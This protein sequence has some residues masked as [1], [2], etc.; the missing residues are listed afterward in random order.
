LKSKEPYCLN[1]LILHFLDINCIKR[2]WIFKMLK[3]GV[4][5]RDPT[6][7]DDS[8]FDS[9]YLQHVHYK[10]VWLKFVYFIHI[11][12][13][14]T[15]KAMMFLNSKRPWALRDLGWRRSNL[16][17]HNQVFSDQ[18]AITKFYFAIGKLC[19]EDILKFFEDF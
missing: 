11:L 8:K 1:C 16:K 18:F 7:S 14:I 12:N 17:A 19:C 13:Y 4:H 5:K 6:Q 10:I 15:S 2:P 3:I 9:S